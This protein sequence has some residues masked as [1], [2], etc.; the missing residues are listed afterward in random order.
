MGYTRRKHIAPFQGCKN[1]VKAP[2]GRNMSAQ[3]EVLWDSVGG[4]PHAKKT[5]QIHSPPKK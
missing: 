1:V 4:N 3:G 2:K 5:D